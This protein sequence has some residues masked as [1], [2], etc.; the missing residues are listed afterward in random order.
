MRKR[1]E[2]DRE[3]FHAPDNA[4]YCY[5]DGS[6]VDNSPGYHPHRSTRFR[7]WGSETS[8][9]VSERELPELYLDRSEC[10]G[11][12]ACEFACPRAAIYMEP[13]EEGFLYP[14]VDAAKCIRCGLCERACVFK[15]RLVERWKDGSGV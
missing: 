6:K 4:P 9:A 14:V 8:A 11:C 5:R 2:S 7:N 1:F 12:T 10:C 3:G 13:D 15:K